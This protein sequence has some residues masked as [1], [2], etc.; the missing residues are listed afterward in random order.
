MNDAP[1][2]ARR[3]LVDRL[4]GE[5][6]AR[7][8][9]VVAALA[10]VPRERF[11]PEELRREAYVDTPLPIGS[12]QTISAPHM[13]AI[14]ADALAAEPGH[15][16]LEVGG[17][18]GYHAAVLAEIVAPGGRVWCVERVP[19]LAEAARARL[20]EAGYGDRVEVVVGDGAE[21]IP[22]AAPFDRISVACAAPSLPGPLVAQLASGGRLLAPVGD[23]DVQ[24][25][26]AADKLA[27]GSLFERRLGECRFVPLRG[28]H[29]FPG[30]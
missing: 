3:R 7:D 27:D 21:G 23:L 30:E 16:V 14:M 17:G 9:R 6:W 29:G 8:P 5:G 28:P 15:R 26:V 20:E 18:S 10:R 12:G 2:A 11:L 22:E 19:A 4:A 24:I 13:V 1:D 25:L